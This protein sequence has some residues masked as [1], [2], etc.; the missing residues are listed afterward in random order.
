MFANMAP[1]TDDDKIL[2][3]AL[4][5]EK[6]WSA[7]TMMRK[8]PSRKWKKSTLF[9]LIKCID[10]TGKTDRRKKV[11]VDRDLQERHQ[12]HKLSATSSAAKKV[13]LAQARIREKSNMRL[14]FHD[15]I[16]VV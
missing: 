1:L 10:K 3:K 8:F 2:I 15:R 6:G 16:F 9:D 7:L 11:A 14:V 12:T 4:R 13:V 5:L